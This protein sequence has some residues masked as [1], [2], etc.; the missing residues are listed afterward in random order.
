MCYKQPNFIKKEIDKDKV[1]DMWLYHIDRMERIMEIDSEDEAY[2]FDV[3]YML[4]PL[5]ESISYNL[6]SKPIRDYLRLLGF[7][8]KEAQVFVSV[9]RNGIIHNTHQY[10]LEYLNGKISW[11]I[12]SSGG[13]V[14]IRPYDKGYISTDFPEDNTPPEKVFEYEDLSEKL[15][16]AT[17]SLDRLIAMI[18]DDLETRKK[19]YDKEKIPFIVGQKI[20]ANKP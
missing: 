8:D 15:S 16:M 17:L 10:E 1:F 12:T 5:I 7:S 4:F 2:S 9:F 18:R 6:F 3:A 11:G 13:N 14:G 19:S 20:E